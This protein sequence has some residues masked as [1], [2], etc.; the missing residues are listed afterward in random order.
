VIQHADSP[1]QAR[2]RARCAGRREACAQ[3]RD[4]ERE[5]Q[6]AVVLRRGVHGAQHGRIA[7]RLTRKQ[8]LARGD[9]RQ[10]VEEEETLGQ[11]RHAAEPQVTAPEVHQLVAD[12]HAL[13][14]IGQGVEARPGQQDDRREQ[15]GDHGRLDAIGA[16]RGGRADQSDLFGQRVDDVEQSRVRRSSR[17]DQPRVR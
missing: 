14:C 13:Q 16:E 6:A 10:R 17:C 5:E 3:R 2:E 12:R 8:V 15:A 1:F 11:R 9:V 7:G 4:A